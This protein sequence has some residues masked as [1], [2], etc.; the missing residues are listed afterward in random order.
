MIFKAV[1]SRAVAFV[2]PM[3]Q[4]SRR[5]FIRSPTRNLPDRFRGPLVGS[6][7]GMGLFGFTLHYCSEMVDRMH[8]L[9]DGTFNPKLHRTYTKEEFQN[10][11]FMMTNEVPEEDDDEEDDEEDEEDEE[12]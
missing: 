5:T 12:D 7:I 1:S 2:K 9:E 4:M 10:F 3:Q 6:L 8:D 11:K